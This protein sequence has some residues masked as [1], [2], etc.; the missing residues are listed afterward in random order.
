MCALIT[1]LKRLN[2]WLRKIRLSDYGNNVELMNTKY[3]SQKIK[4]G[5]NIMQTVLLLLHSSQGKLKVRL[6]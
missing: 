1:F 4:P 6:K 5:P 3:V 2:L